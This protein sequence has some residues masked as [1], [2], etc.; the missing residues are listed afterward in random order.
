MT[1][2]TAQRSEGQKPRELAFLSF[3]I[4]L[5]VSSCLGTW[6]VSRNLTLVLI[7][8]L[9][10]LAVLAFSARGKTDLHLKGLGFAFQVKRE[11]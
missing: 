8:M 7:V 9:A 1:V 10:E 11:S 6:E 5:V 4:A 2:E 3:I